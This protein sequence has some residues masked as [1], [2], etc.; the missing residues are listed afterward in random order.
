MSTHLLDLVGQICVL[1]FPAFQFK[2][3]RIIHGEKD[4]YE[5]SVF[6]VYRGL[7]EKKAQG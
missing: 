5:A 7:V 4:E 2:I 1:H 3:C 6:N